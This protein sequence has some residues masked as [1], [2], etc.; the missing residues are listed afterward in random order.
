MGSI[1][2]RPAVHT[3]NKAG[4]SG[5]SQ[6]QNRRWVMKD[7][8]CVC[9]LVV[10]LQEFNSISKCAPILGKPKARNLT[11]KW[12][13]NWRRLVPGYG[14]FWLKIN[15]HIGQRACMLELSEE[16]FNITGTQ[17]PP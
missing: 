1:D 7:L 17:L 6:S 4:Y 13:G 8:A 11:L 5:A 14:I 9:S 10:N 16:I 12:I 15:Y 3:P 2:R